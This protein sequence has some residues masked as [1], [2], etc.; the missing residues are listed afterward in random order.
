M[1]QFKLKYSDQANIRAL[2]SS[3]LLTYPNGGCFIITDREKVIYKQP[4]PQFDVSDIEVN[5]PNK[6][7]G[8]AASVLKSEKNID[9]YLDASMYG[10]QVHVLAGPLWDD[11]EKEIVGTWILAL[12]WID[13][14]TA[15]FEHFAPMLTDMFPEGAMLYTTDTTN[16]TKRQG[17]VK[18]DTPKLQVGE[19]VE[20]Y[21]IAAKAI[22]TGQQINQELPEEF[23]GVPAVAMCKPIFDNAQNK[24]VGMLGVALPKTL[25]VKLRNMAGNLGEGLTEISAAMQEL[26]ASSSEIAQNQ[27]LLN[28]EINNVSRLAEEITQVLGFIKQIADETKML[29]LNAAIEAARAGEQGRGFGVV[30]EEIRKLSDES[31]ETVI[32]IRGLIDEINESLTKTHNASELTLR[33]ATEVAA[34]NEETTA[35]IEQL[36]NMSNE[37]LKVAQQL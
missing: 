23:Y 10:V 33:H 6:P 15:A 20:K 12:P 14:V 21:P 34:A 31:K 25:D 27:T 7:G 37:L 22:Q 2:F 29:G 32:R 4:T 8:V 16:I 28:D 19:S 24:V 26:A 3:L 30:A 11:T 17:S 35:S 36:V 18:F 1:E 9:I 13:P 5:K